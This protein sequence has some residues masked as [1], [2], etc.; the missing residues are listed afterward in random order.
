MGDDSK[1]GQMANPWHRYRPGYRGNLPCSPSD[2]ESAELVYLAVHVRRAL[3]RRIAGDCRIAGN[4]GL[5]SETEL[6]WCH[7]ISGA[8]SEMMDVWDVSD[9]HRIYMERSEWH[10]IVRPPSVVGCELLR[11]L[12]GL[13]AARPGL[14]RCC[15]RQGPVD[16]FLRIQDASGTPEWVAKWMNVGADEA[17][18][19]ARSPRT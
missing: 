18:S 2:L 4:P 19:S 6:E 14:F 5:P 11:F 8:F 13:C 10:P 16:E 17:R 7:A 12:G 9:T 3:L 15:I 1:L